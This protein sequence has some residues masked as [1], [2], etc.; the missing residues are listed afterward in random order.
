MNNTL[1]KKIVSIVTVV[2]TFI[3]SIS[4]GKATATAFSFS[5][6]QIGKEVA[7]EIK[8]TDDTYYYSFTTDG[9]D[10]FYNLK[11]SA[12]MD[13]FD[14]ITFELY[15]DSDLNKKLKE[16][17]M[18]LGDSGI[19]DFYKELTP[20]TKY[21]LKLTGR[22]NSNTPIKYKL[23]IN[24][25]MDDVGDAASSSKAISLNSTYN[26]TI[27]NDSDVDCFKLTTS[28]FSNYIITFKNF[29]KEAQL[30][31]KVYDTSDMVT[32]SHV[33]TLPYNSALNNNTGK[34]SLKA[35]KT[36]YMAITS[37]AGTKYSIGVNAAAP[38]S[39]K[40]AS[41]KKKVT[42]SWKKVAKAKGYE[43]Y[44][45]TGKSGK[46][47]KIKTITKAGTVKYVDKSVKKKSTYRYKIRAYATK[48]GKKYFT[49]FSPV[50][51]VKVK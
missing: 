38:D 18:H 11:I 51:S 1:F 25:I 48:G 26:Y 37:R 17:S 12:A 23:A 22:V 15:Q 33:I 49:V 35:G 6:V 21:F 2:C 10:S 16:S 39:V 40:M 8:C 24:R 19:F 32:A 29:S 27:Q 20:N 13:S 42:I 4:W 47:K 46:F 9:S 36:Y 14:G 3:Y 5:N 41:S 7:G 31:L 50:K 43:I 34:I 28:A 44:K 45:A 30:N